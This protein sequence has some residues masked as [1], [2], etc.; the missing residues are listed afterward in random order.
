MKVTGEGR[1]RATLVGD[2]VVQSGKK[3]G[4]QTFTEE[5]MDLG[6]TL[7]KNRKPWEAFDKVYWLL[8]ADSRDVCWKQE[9]QLGFC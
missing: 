8:W 9:D 3:R 4:M 2:G 6:P 5:V 7:G 1:Q